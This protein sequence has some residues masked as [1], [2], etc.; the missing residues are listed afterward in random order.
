LNIEDY[1]S[2]GVIEAYVM[3]L[4][5][6]EEVQILECVQKNN[7]SVKQAVLDAQETL[8][9]LSQ[10]Q[11]VA[12]PSHLKS[13]IWAKIQA[14]EEQVEEI[15]TEHEP[16]D[17]QPVYEKSQP[18]QKTSYW[19]AAASVLLVFSVGFLGYFLLERKELKGEL[20]SIK[21]QQN[22][23]QKTYA[24]LNEKWHL[25]TNPNVKTVALAGVEKHPDS[26]AVVYLNVEN[27]KTY[28]SLE[29]LPEP[30]SGY[31]YQLWALVNGT[32]VD[33]GVY[34]HKDGK[35]LQEMLA[36]ANAQAYAITL[37]KEGGSATPTLE[38][39]Y[40]MGSI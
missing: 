18:K 25:S 23:E 40:V 39:M 30:P 36:V 3:G 15:I 20:S 38:E 37:E 32:P 16:I 19:A 26:K 9:H 13:A 11:A 2:S 27:K 28:L 1:I 29:N 24:A 6:E 14:E 22:E 35:P 12:P 31:Q 33:A 21:A 34:A 7:A 4:A 8:G 5:T 17:F 10:V